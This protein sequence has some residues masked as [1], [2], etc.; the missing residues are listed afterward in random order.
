MTPQVAEVFIQRCK[1]LNES[2]KILRVPRIITEQYPEGLGSTI[3][4]LDLDLESIVS[5]AILISKTRFSM[6]TDEVKEQ[7][8]R[9]KEDGRTQVILLGMETHACITQTS[10]DLLEHGLNVHIAVDACLS[11][12]YLSF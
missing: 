2:A 10:L 7:L 9:Y 6:L 11:L 12:R 3:S 5:P 8:H 1:L 4:E